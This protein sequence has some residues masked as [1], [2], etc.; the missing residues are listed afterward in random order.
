M[1]DRRRRAGRVFR[2]GSAIGVA[3]AA[4]VFANEILAGR[5]FGPRVGLTT[6][7]FGLAAGIAATIAWPLALW[8]CGRR[9][10]TARFA[11]MVVLLSI[12]TIGLAALFFLVQ[13]LPL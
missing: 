2:F 4:A 8:V 12:G 5:S 6:A 13:R 7:L 10:P 9:P 1:P 3:S 11:G